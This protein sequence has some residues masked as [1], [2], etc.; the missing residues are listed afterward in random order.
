M[1]N[2]RSVQMTDLDVNLLSSRK[3]PKKF[4]MM[5]SR[6]EMMNSGF[7]RMMHLVVYLLSSRKTP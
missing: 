4:A 6:F 7:A 1:M 5:N 3:T 2:S